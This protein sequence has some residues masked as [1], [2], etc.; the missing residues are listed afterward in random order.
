MEL[1]TN[2][3][4]VVNIYE[5]QPTSS[6]PLHL[7]SS[8]PLL[9]QAGSFSFSPVSFHA[10]F[11]TGQEIVILDVQASKP[12]LKTKLDVRYSQWGPSLKGDFSPSGDFFALCGK[13][14]KV[15]VWKN[16]PTGY[17]LWCSF[18]ARFRIETPF[19]SPSSASLLCWSQLGIQLFYLDNYLD[20]LSDVE[21]RP[22]FQYETHMIAY[23]TDGVHI[24]TAKKQNSI[25]TVLNCHSGT[26][27]QSINTDMQIHDIKTVGD[28]IFAVDLH[29][30][31]SWKLEPGGAAYSLCGIHR[32]AANEIL[33]FRA[34][35][36]QLVLSHDCSQIAFTVQDRV[37]LYHVET[38]EILKS[39]EWKRSF[40]LDIQFSPDVC[41]LWLTRP[42]LHAGNSHDFAKLNTTED[43][44]IVEK[45]LY[46]QQPD[47]RVGGVLEGRGL[48]IQAWSTNLIS[49]HGC[50]A[51][52]GSQ[53]VT[54]SR[55]S[56]L[57]WLPPNWRIKN[58]WDMRWNDRFLI[59][60]HYHHPQLIIIEFQP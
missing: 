33:A 36:D 14:N 43:W 52:I 23:T 32:V 55:G 12:L 26:L 41:Q 11:V 29:K 45:V 25:I 15:H 50:H 51:G 34:G 24:A 28:I 46:G 40:L 10:S 59:L 8:F 39:I 27:S 3:K 17:I 38:Q 53:W 1:D 5:L 56:R 60:L 4:F 21:V 7:L 42:I 9:P 31:S 13:G 37:F 2:G 54:A 18:N 30:L 35:W 16:T 44:A 22:G 48:D 6:L 20:P 19:W 49:P 57:L 47:G 58:E